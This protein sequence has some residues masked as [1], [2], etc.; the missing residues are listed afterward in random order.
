M[1][2]FY[3]TQVS[4]S[5]EDLEGFYFVARHYVFGYKLVIF[6]SREEQEIKFKAGSIFKYADVRK[7]ECITVCTCPL[8]TKMVDRLGFWLYRK[9]KKLKT[10]KGKEQK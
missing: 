9:I 10:P 5:F 1:K 4:S 3:D 2:F 7:K 6:K 8:K